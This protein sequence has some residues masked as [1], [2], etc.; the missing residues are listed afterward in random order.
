MTSDPRGTDWI[1]LL[2]A[3]DTRAVSSIDAASF[4]HLVSSWASPA[5]MTLHSPNRYA[6]QVPLRAVDPQSALSSAIWL[7]RDALCRSGLPEW[8]LLRVEVMTAE[9]FEQELRA[10]EVDGDGAGAQ[11]PATSARQDVVAEELLRRALHDAVTGLPCRELFLGEVRR[12][13]TA[14]AAATDWALIVVHVDGGALD[15]SWAHPAPDDVLM[16]LAGR[17][18]EA[19]RRA[20]TV[21]RVGPAEFGILVEASQGNDGECLSRRIVERLGLPPLRYDYGGPLLCTVSVGLVTTS[22]DADADQLILKAELAVA[23][24]RAAGGNCYRRFA[25]SPDS[26]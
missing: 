4:A 14:E 2:E 19:V 8:K 5:P 22:H 17:L 1:V 11:V 21:A 20:D 16:V 3:A 15:G 24:A 13:L 18:S 12:A 23:A 9:E 7:W 26:V 10:A 25:V 6:L